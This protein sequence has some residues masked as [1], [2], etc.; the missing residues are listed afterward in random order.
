MDLTTQQRASY[1]AAVRDSLEKIEQ[2]QKNANYAAFD[3]SLKF[4]NWMESQATAEAPQTCVYAGW[5]G[6][7]EDVG[8]RRL[9][10]SP[11][12]AQA[13][14]PAGQ[15][16]CRPGL[17]GAGLC[18]P[19]GASATQTCSVRSQASEVSQQYLRDSSLENDWNNLKQAI[20]SACENNERQT[21]PC[22]IFR[23]RLADL[24]SLI[25]SLPA[26]QATPPSVAQQEVATPPRGSATAPASSAPPPTRLAPGRAATTAPVSA[27]PAATAA[28]TAKAAP[29]STPP[30]KDRD[31]G[32]TGLC[33]AF[34]TLCTLDALSQ[35]LGFRTSANWVAFFAAVK[36]LC[37]F[38][39]PEN[40]SVSKLLDGASTKEIYEM[41]MHYG[42]CSEETYLPYS[43]D[44]PPG[45]TPSSAGTFQSQYGISPA[46]A[47]YLYCPPNKND[48]A[49]LY[50]QRLMA[51][52]GRAGTDSRFTKCAQES[53][54]TL[55][56][57]NASNIRCQ[58]QLT[59]LD[60]GGGQP[61]ADAQRSATLR[62]LLHNIRGPISVS[63]I[64]PARWGKN[65]GHCLTVE[66]SDDSK[67]TFTIKNSGNGV[68]EAPL[69][70]TGDE[71]KIVQATYLNCIGSAYS[72]FNRAVTGAAQSR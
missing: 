52:T 30:C 17:F 65:E 60:G 29:T 33:S 46:N 47:K 5:I 70:Y 27:A 67:G 20:D 68:A 56:S 40:T 72:G 43:K 32:K 21:G 6:H 10:M 41:A 8:G 1:L 24:H 9:C 38:N 36:N 48:N 63:I 23:T 42:F 2:N 12:E 66:A 34:C 14:C 55:R 64:D 62:T 45:S 19:R 31:Q 35:P 37:D 3:R 39:L 44:E 18:V 61:A 58:P 25:P 26:P 71:R 57:L 53:L 51:V 49:V 4:L 59:P 69:K 16:G 7:F 15:I 54:K 28:A 13:N 22:N 50:N 11:P